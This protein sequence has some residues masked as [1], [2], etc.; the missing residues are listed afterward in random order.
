[1]SKLSEIP[2]LQRK[3]KKILKGMGP[4]RDLQVQLEIISNMRQESPIADFER[5]LER[6]ERRQ[7]AEIRKELKRSSKR[8]LTKG[9][10][11]VRAEFVRLHDKGGRE[12]IRNAVERVL[13][14]RRNEFLR[15]RKRFKP[16]DEE[17][18][19]AMRI[20]LKKLRYVVEA[21]QPVLGSYARERARHMHSFQ[22]LLGD[23]RDLELLRTRLEKWATKR[24]NIIAIVPALENLQ[25]KRE[26]LMQKIVE[27]AA[28]LD[29][30]FPE[31]HLKPT[32][33]KTLA[34]TASETAATDGTVLPPNR[35]RA[36]AAR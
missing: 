24:G 27:S 7:I 15:T 33:E 22:Q 3:F 1:M 4:L 20:A 16:S 14:L 25:E 8:R 2:V 29:N 23:T 17:T 28:A 10:K 30:I 13:R 34:V 31:E 18:L 26:G 6:R 12:R 35:I 19:H 36:A 11:D 32:A 5:S 21:A 9:V